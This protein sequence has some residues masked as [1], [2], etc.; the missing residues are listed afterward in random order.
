VDLALV[1]AFIEVVRAGSFTKAAKALGLPKSTVSRHVSRLEEGLGALLLVRTT[2]SLRLTEVGEAFYHRVA[3]ALD[4]VEEAAREVAEQR[5]VPQGLLRISVPSDYE[6]L[7]PIV[8]S[9]LRRY[10]EV[11]IEV[12]VSAGMMDLVAEGYDLAIR[13]GR[14]RDSSL[15]ARKL[16][17]VEFHLCASPSYL[18]AH[19]EPRT[20][21]ELSDHS[22]VLFRPQH[23]VSRWALT[24]PD[25]VEQVDVRGTLW[26]GDLLFARAAAVAGLGIS[27][28][29][30]SLFAP[31]LGLVRVLPNHMQPAGAVHIVY[32]A[33][34]HVP[35]KVRA[36]RDHLLESGLWGE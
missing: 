1:P 34:R 7:A 3:T 5:A 28:L 19:G 12:D 31:G 13:A 29:P 11:S 18:E 32:P 2:R 6:R 4:S 10:P 24:G 14:L 15:I 9:F 35:A 25:G 26:V 36:F 27:L 17:T 21:S 23:G 16:A 33:S 30:S 22:C 8:A 20:V